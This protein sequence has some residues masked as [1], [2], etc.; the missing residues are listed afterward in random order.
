MY[1]LNTNIF[2]DEFII[3]ILILG[4][5]VQ[6]CPLP[7]KPPI[8]HVLFLRFSNLN[9][10]LTWKHSVKKKDILPPSGKQAESSGY[11]SFFL[12][13][14]KFLLLFSYSC[15]HFLAIPPPHPRQTHLPPLPP[16]PP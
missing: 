9:F 14:L 8:S 15:L 2:E 12:F 7:N 13:V 3:L 4:F 6:S 10:Q 11:N 1:I 16:P 5:I